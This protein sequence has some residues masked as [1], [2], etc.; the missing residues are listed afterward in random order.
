MRVEFD[1]GWTSV[2]AGSGK[3][4][5][6]LVT[7]GDDTAESESSKPEEQAEEAEPA[8]EAEDGPEDTES[9]LALPWGK[10]RGTLINSGR[11]CAAEADIAP[12]K[13]VGQHVWVKERGQ[14]KVGE[15]KSKKRGYGSHSVEFRRGGTEQLELLS[16]DGPSK[17]FVLRARV[18]EEA[19]A[20][21]LAAIAED[22]GVRGLTPEQ[23][24][25]QDMAAPG[26]IRAAVR[27]K[28]PI[29]P[30]VPPAASASPSH[31]SSEPVGVL[32]RM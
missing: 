4:L 3:A 9:L 27:R 18:T 32:R 11:W 16:S 21:G 22:D 30:A 19:P 12:E 14:G 25:A 24:R 23:L 5:L 15:Y 13:L 10:A 6:E 1:R 29:A 7:D 28:T 20:S 2:T 17:H 31:K 26:G 8:Y